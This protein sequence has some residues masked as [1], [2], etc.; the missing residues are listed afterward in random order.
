VAGDIKSKSR[1]VAR[2]GKSRRAGQESNICPFSRISIPLNIT[3]VIHRYGEWTMLMLGESVLSLLIVDV[4]ETSKYY[5]TLFSGIVSITLLEYLHF[6]SQPHDP[7]DHAMRRSKE[8]GIV[9]SYLMTLY[10]M[11]LVALGT[12]YKMLLYEVNKEK[13]Y[14]TA[15]ADDP[16]HRRS[17]FS[18]VLSRLL[19]AGADDSASEYDPNRRQNIAHWFCISMAIVWFCSDAMILVH[20]GIKDNLGRCRVRT[21]RKLIATGLV[22]S[23]VGL[24]AWIGT[25]G[26]YVTEPEKLA[27]IGFVGIVLQVLL[28]F[29]GSIA[30]DEN[31]TDNIFSG[32]VEESNGGFKTWPNTSQPQAAAA[33]KSSDFILEKIEE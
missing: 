9:F 2:L 24:I 11:A 12:S 22:L 4:S 25:L 29:V 23:R 18:A 13:T 19:A 32:F 16:E 1:T 15:V 7:D 31:D 3:F 27:F 8:A 33:E 5:S 21:S 17:L 28:R 26:Q 14:S 10:S 6:R 20:H 30:F